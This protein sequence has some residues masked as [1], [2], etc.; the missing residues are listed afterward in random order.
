MMSFFFIITERLGVPTTTHSQIDDIAE[1]ILCLLW[2]YKIISSGYWKER[3]YVRKCLFEN[4]N[5]E[6]LFQNFIT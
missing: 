6:K 1:R 2:D 5:V 4:N 3:K